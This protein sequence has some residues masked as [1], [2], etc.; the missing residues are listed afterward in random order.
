[1]TK[2]MLTVVGSAVAVGDGIEIPDDVAANW[3]AVMTEVLANGGTGGTVLYRTAGGDWGCAHTGDMSV[4][5]AWGLIDSAHTYADAKNLAD[6][7]D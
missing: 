7:S 3:Q 6:I 4:T 1:M 2:P 5:D